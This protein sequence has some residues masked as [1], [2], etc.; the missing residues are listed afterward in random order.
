MRIVELFVENVKG[1]REVLVRP[2]AALVE[3]CG[4]NASGKST[5]LD[6]IWWAIKGARHIQDKPIRDGESE[7]MITIDTGRYKVKRVFKDRGD[8]EKYLTRVE[9]RTA[10]GGIL[11][12]PQRILDDLLGA[13][14]LDPLEF[15]R[16]KPLA[17]ARR[18]LEI[19]GINLD[20]HDELERKDYAERTHH[21]KE[22]ASCGRCQTA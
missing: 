7:G 22:A 5:L 19:A 17:Q 3:I 16:S 15:V 9:V 20:E 14:S 18:I 13:L 12:G 10:Q 1:V 11:K 8:G 6:A 2:A 21:N 4:E